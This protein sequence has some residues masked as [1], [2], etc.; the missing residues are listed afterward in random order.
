MIT[1]NSSAIYNGIKSDNA[2]P[3]NICDLPDDGLKND[4][5]MFKHYQIAY[6]EEFW[7]NDTKVHKVVNHYGQVFYC[8]RLII[9]P[10][11][12]RFPFH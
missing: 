7:L 2:M 4:F 6:K 11:H 9:L 12:S 10:D 8:F 5:C 3:L 1:A